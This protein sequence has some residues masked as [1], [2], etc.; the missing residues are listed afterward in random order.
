MS[1]PRQTSTPEITL[2]LEVPHTPMDPNTVP[3]GAGRVIK[4]RD[5]GNRL[6]GLTVFS[7]E[8]KKKKNPGRESR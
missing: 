2:L 4:K 7:V 1:S 6:K 5:T 8:T 3:R